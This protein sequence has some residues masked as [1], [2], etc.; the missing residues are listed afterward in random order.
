M[1]LSK[2]PAKGLVLDIS[3]RFNLLNNNNEMRNNENR[4]QMWQSV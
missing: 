2:G 4:L 3:G 1:S